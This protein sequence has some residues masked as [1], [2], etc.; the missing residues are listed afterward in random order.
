MANLSFLGTSCLRSLGCVS[1]VVGA[2]LVGVTEIS[3]LLRAFPASL[4]STLRQIPC[5]YES[6]FRPSHIEVGLPVYRL[7]PLE[8]VQ[9][10]LLQVW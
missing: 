7:A 9:R 2:V 10:F 3:L 6:C 4:V 8:G 5:Q 1:L